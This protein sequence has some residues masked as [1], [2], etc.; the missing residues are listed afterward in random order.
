MSEEVRIQRTVYNKDS[1]NNTVNSSFSYF[2]EPIEEEDPD[3]VEE[4]FRL[5]EKLYLEIPLEGDNSHEYL[6][7][8]SSEL[9]EVNV[10]DELIEPLLEEISELRSELLEKERQILE[11]QSE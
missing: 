2:T 7:R 5:Y 9:I 8:R 1:I 10:N 11:S 3:T 6:I 4:F